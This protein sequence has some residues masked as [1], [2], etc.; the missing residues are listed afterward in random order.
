MFKKNLAA[1]VVEAKQ[2]RV[3]VAEPDWVLEIPGRSSEC[4][5][6]ILTREVTRQGFVMPR[7]HCKVAWR[8]S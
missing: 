4:C 1:P 6:R 3:S 5:Q 2:T 8:I 7:D